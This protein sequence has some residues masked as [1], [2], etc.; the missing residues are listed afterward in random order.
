METTFKA[1]EICGLR[2]L[3]TLDPKNLSS[4][5]DDVRSLLADDDYI[6]TY[7]SLEE[8]KK[9]LFGKFHWKKPN[10]FKFSIGDS[11]SIEV[12]VDIASQLVKEMKLIK[13][14]P[15]SLA[16]KS[17]VP[18]T[19]Y[20][21]SSSVTAPEVGASTSSVQ[22]KKK[23]L[24]DT[25]SR[26]LLKVLK[27]GGEKRIVY[28]TSDYQ[29]DESLET[30]TCLSCS[31]PSKPHAV[32][33]FL[34]GDNWNVSNLTRHISTVHTAKSIELRTQQARMLNNFVTRPS[35]SPSASSGG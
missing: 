16:L 12:I 11:M 1:L 8:D 23:S 20:P 22:K 33:A 31:T 5:E 7:A 29:C 18:S 27:K 10:E 32:K 19:A 13:S 34:T 15:K 26:W 4:I 30:V 17:P 24:N 9:N 21:S 35:A 14:L 6:Q 3:A 2:L 28:S 25:I